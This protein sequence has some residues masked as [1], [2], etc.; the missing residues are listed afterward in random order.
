VI[1]TGYKPKIPET[2]SYPLGAITDVPQHKLLRIEFQCW[3]GFAKDRVP[4]APYCVLRACYSGPGLGPSGWSI[5]VHA[6]PRPIKH[7][8]QRKLTSEALP[9][10]K[11]WLLSNSHSSDRDGSHQLTFYFDELKDEITS[12]DTSSSEWGTIR[13]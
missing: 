2:L 7:T 6:V 10:I 12:K 5:E 9:K 1:P 13:G 4:S 8:I 11:D 3:R